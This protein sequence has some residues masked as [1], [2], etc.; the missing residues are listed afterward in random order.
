MAHRLQSVY[1]SLLGSLHRFFSVVFTLVIL[2]LL[3]LFGLQ[4]KHPPSI[5][6]LWP[7]VQL[8][9]WGDPLLGLLA[10]RLGTAW[11]TVGPSPS[12]LP[13]GV[14]AGVW[15][16]KIFIDGM[17]LKVRRTVLRL[18]PMPVN[19][20]SQAR[21]TAEG[22]MGF[23]DAADLSSAPSGSR[24]QWLKRYL[25]LKK[26]LSGQKKHLAFLSVD[27][28][29]STT[30]KLGEDKLTIEHAFR[31]YKTLVESILKEYGVWK[32][33]WT[34]DGVMAC[35]LRPDLGVSAARKIIRQL[36][37][38]NE[39]VNQMKKIFRVRCGLNAGDVVADES[40]PMEEIADETVDVAGH[41]QKYAKPDSLWVSEEVW[42]QL[43]DQSGFNSVDTT[44]D[45]RKVRA[46]QGEGDVSPSA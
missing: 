21:P 38:F 11:P 42:G 24:M 8:H 14:A 46:W 1:R 40:I 12:Y 19:V 22:E 43:S 34:P 39:N 26:S 33:A 35:F 45:G 6:T 15:I 10:K 29:G 2:C 25:A 5:D 13:L 32:S 28:V 16:I 27:V 41:L 31:E 44:V 20:E 4:F 30:M 3:V 9:G 7:V 17:L 23:L 37:A 36:K 18:T